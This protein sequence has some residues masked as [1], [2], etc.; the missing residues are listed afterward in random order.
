MADLGRDPSDPRANMCSMPDV[1][2]PVETGTQTEAIIAAE[3]VRHG[4]RVLLPFGFNHRYDLG[5]DVNGRLIRVQCKT[6][7]LRNGC[8]AFPTVSTRS[9]TK[10]VV[11]RGHVGEADVFV[12]RCVPLEKLY[13]IAVADA[14]PNYVFLRIAPTTNRQEARIRWAR[15]YE[16][17]HGLQEAIAAAATP[18][19]ETGFEPVA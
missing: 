18:K 14:P 9:N 4:Y 19:P 7:R 2:H 16:L 10:R 5:V 11:R 1:P 15:H 12:A 6:A 8:V 17:P 3:L 13:A